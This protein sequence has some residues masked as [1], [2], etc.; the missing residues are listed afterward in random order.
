MSR[1]LVGVVGRPLKAGRVAHWDE[2]V[3]AVP[4]PYLEA[5]ERAGAFAAILDPFPP[6]PGEAAALVARLDGLVLTGGAD[7]DPGRYGAERHPE[8]YGTNA[9]SDA[10]ELALV[11]AVVAAGLPTLAIC[12]G[13]QVL[14][15]ARGGTL[16]Q[17]L[18][19]RPGLLAHGT[20]GGGE[21]T[22]HEVGLE[23]GSLLAG[24]MG[25]ARPMCA[26]H[27]HQAVAALGA[28]LRVTA[29]ADDGVVEG[30]ELEGAWILAVQWHPEDT[31]AE[32]PAQQRLFD[33]LVERAQG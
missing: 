4:S 24:T 14:N 1:P 33:A 28:G 22:R 20:P 8:V 32:D 23:P 16:E 30:L 6:G 31:A 12:R 19:D 17:H 2:P 7:V 3:T 25:T 15:V 27:H 11:D 5:V 13:L 10:F 9:R 29:R 18:P 26:S 21:G